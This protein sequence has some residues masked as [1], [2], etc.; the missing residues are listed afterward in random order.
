[1]LCRRESRNS[2]QCSH[3]LERRCR[4]IIL[5]LLYK[6]FL[7]MLELVDELCDEASEGSMIGRAK[8]NYSGRGKTGDVEQGCVCLQS[9]HGES[10]VSRLLA[11]LPNS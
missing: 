2:E 11:F 4:K 1:M 10:I 8:R 9:G 5:S 7:K 6:I 3:K